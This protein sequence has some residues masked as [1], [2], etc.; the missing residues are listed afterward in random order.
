MYGRLI[1]IPYLVSP[2][3]LFTYRQTASLAAGSYTFTNGTKAV[4]TPSRPIQGNVLYIFWTMDFAMDIAEQDYLGAIT[5]LPQFSMYLQSDA[6]APAFREPIPLSKYFSTMPYAL[7]ILG[8]DLLS[9]QA[10]AAQG[11]LFNRLLGG[12]DGV[13][14]QTSA[15]LGKATVT[16]TV[17]FSVQ[18]ISEAKFIAEFRARA[19]GRRDS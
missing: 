9:S 18:E 11:F 5:T 10:Q 16:A 13:L 2:P 12:I 7:A 15:L 6:S 14:N 3:L 19:E 4:F 8:N 17:V 1:D